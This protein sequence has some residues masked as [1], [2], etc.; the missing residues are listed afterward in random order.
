PPAGKIDFSLLSDVSG[1]LAADYGRTSFDEAAHVLYADLAVRNAGQYAADAPL[2]VGVKNIS[3]PSVRLRGFDGTTPDGVPY[4]DLSALVAGG[5]LR[6]GELTGART[7][8][9]Y[10]PSGVQFSY[11][12]VFLG[13]LNRAPAISTVPDIEALAGRPYRYDVDASDPDGDAVTYT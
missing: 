11:D 9:F 5:T 13:K 3:D 2:L 6:P 4:F 12:L 7:L 10:D 8:A 1:S